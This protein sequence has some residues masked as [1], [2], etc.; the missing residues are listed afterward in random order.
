MAT[1]VFTNARVFTS[2]GDGTL[3]DA[4]VTQGDKVLFVGGAEDAAA[5]G[6]KVSDFHAAGIQHLANP[7]IMPQSPTCTA[8]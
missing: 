7:S 3:H 6:T 5:I 8:V 2:A 4:L 1:R